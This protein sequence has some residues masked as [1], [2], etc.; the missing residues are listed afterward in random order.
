MIQVLGSDTANKDEALALLR[1]INAEETI[2]RQRTAM[3]SFDSGLVAYN[4]RDF[5]QSLAIFGLIDD[6]MLPATKKAQLRELKIASSA[7]VRNSNPIT[8][9]MHRTPRIL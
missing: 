3:K 7:G 1:T 9:V 4:N 5:R 2:Q 6:S 8:P